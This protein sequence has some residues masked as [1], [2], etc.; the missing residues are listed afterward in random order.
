LA[1]NTGEAIDACRIHIYKKKKKI[2]SLDPIMENYDEM[3]KYVIN[4][5]DEKKI[6]IIT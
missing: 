5:I 1:S 6:E 2:V 4:H 3:V